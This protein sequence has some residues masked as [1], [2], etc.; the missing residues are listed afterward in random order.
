MVFSDFHTHIINM[1]TDTPSGEE[2]TPSEPRRRGRPRRSDSNF[3]PRDRSSS[4]PRSRS[5]STRSTRRRVDPN[6]TPAS[7]FGGSI[8]D[9]ARNQSY[10]TGSQQSLSSAASTYNIQY[11][12]HQHNS[13]HRNAAAGGPAKGGT[14]RLQ[15]PAE[16]RPEFSNSVPIRCYCLRNY[17]IFI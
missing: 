4:S 17:G 12:Q 5:S 1:N 2:Q 11:F 10:S 15:I 3:T 14:A 9:T 16:F 7:V 8:R 13:S 6:A